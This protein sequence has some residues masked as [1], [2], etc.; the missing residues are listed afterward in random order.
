M[1]HSPRSTCSRPRT[2][3]ASC[4][5]CGRTRKCPPAPCSS[6]RTTSRK[7]SCWPIAWW[8]WAR[9]RAASAPISASTFRARA[10]ARI[11]FHETVDYIYRVLTQPDL[12][13]APQPEP[14][15]CRGRAAARAKYPMLPHARPGGI[16]GLLEMLLDRNGRDDLY[17]LADD[18]AFE[19]DDLLP[20]VE[21][22]S[23]LGFLIVQE[24]DAEITPEGCRF[25]EAGIL[26]RKEL[27]K[28]AALARH[29]H[30]PDHA[31]ARI[32]ADHTL[33]DEFFHDL[34]D[35]HFTEE[36]IRAPARNRGQLGPLRRAVRPRRFH[37]AF[38]IPEETASSPR[39][40]RGN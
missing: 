12:V 6:S 17:R 29:A 8:C 14:R 25:A 31:R 38:F 4:W 13:P 5:S 23:L 11:R 33:P 21:A 2:F 7:P 19:I 18:L 28:V 36:E 32:K 39:G 9:T 35:E 34:L 3:A 15:R 16:A 40:S 26:R 1:S 27:F 37:R 30:S 24:G 22:A 20:I 10:I